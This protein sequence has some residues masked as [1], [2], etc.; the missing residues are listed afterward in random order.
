MTNAD[1]STKDRGN[2]F[3]RRV[4]EAA[5]AEILQWIATTPNKRGKPIPGDVQGDFDYWFDGGAFK[6][7]TG[8]VEYQFTNGARA[9]V[10]DP[11]PGLSVGITFA[12]GCRVRVQ[13]ET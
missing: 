6:V 8:Y 9:G 5:V 11:T 3:D 10:A 1:E 4:H 2:I 13:Q 7:G 12:N